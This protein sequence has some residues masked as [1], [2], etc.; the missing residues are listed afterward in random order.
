MSL[1]FLWNSNSAVAQIRGVKEGDI[2]KVHLKTN[3]EIVGRLVSVS[4]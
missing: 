2:I 4:G 3:D 1:L